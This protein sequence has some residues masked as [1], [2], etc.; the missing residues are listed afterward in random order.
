MCRQIQSRTRHVPVWEDSS[1]PS[2]SPSS[3][4][5]LLEFINSMTAP[6]I[7]RQSKGE[8]VAG[9]RHQNTTWCF[10]ATVSLIQSLASRQTTSDVI[11]KNESRALIFFSSPSSLHLFCSSCIERKKECLTSVSANFHPFFLFGW[12]NSVDAATFRVTLETV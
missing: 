12:K 7:Q 5:R 2:R 6:W 4:C 3:F 10:S 9:G 1:C 11:D 8:A